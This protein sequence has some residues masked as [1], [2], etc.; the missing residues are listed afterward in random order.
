[1]TENDTTIRVKPDVWELIDIEQA[2]G[3]SKSDTIK[4]IFNRIEYECGC[5]DYDNSKCALS[6]KFADCVYYSSCM[7]G[8]KPPVLSNGKIEMR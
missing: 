2:K 3:E 1:M 7:S 6:E 5:Y 4:R 8:H